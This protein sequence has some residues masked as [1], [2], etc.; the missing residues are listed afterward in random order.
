[1]NV[2]N[3]AGVAELPVSRRLR[4]G[5]LT[6]NI[7]IAF[8]PPRWTARTA[9]SHSALPSIV[10]RMT[11]QSAIRSNPTATVECPSQ[12]CSWTCCVCRLSPPKAH[13][14]DDALHG[15]PEGRLPRRGLCALPVESR[16]RQLDKA[17]AGS[18][19]S[20]V[21]GFQVIKGLSTD[22]QLGEALS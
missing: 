14:G 10:D 20:G 6:S 2:L 12:P 22:C 1:M 21:S 5:A 4:F 18:G 19:K 8:A 9:V 15:L 7:R 11:S 17:L 16:Q 13:R 3:R